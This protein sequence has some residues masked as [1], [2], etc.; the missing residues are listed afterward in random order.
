MKREAPIEKI[1]CALLFLLTRQEGAPPPG[2]AAMI[3]AHLV[4]LKDH[5]DTAHLPLLRDTCRRLSRQRQSHAQAMA[6]ADKP[7]S[8]MGNLWTLH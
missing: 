2:L 1:L 4:W 8:E 7:I 5:P 6:A 3:D